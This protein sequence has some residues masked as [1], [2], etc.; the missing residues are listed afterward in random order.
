M[1]INQFIKNQFTTKRIYSFGLDI[2]TF[3]KD[4]GNPEE[5]KESQRKRFKDSSIVDEIIKL[6]FDWKKA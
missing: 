2:N 6:D 1:I 5:V 3:R 4:K